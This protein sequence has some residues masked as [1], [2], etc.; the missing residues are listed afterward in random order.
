ME[1]TK[2]IH[3]VDESIRKAGLEIFRKAMTGEQCAKLFEQLDRSD[4]DIHEMVDRI[5]SANGN[6]RFSCMLQ[7]I[8]STGVRTPYGFYRPPIKDDSPDYV[9]DNGNVRRRGQGL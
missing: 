3:E 8:E 1:F 5:Q 4:P 7:I 2:P 6:D 9:F